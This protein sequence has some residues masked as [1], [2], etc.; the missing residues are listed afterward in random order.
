MLSFSPPQWI[1]QFCCLAF[2][3]A[4]TPSTFTKLIRKLTFGRKDFVS[5]LDIILLYHATLDEHIIWVKSLLE[6]ILKFGLTVIPNSS[7]QDG[8][9]VFSNR[10]FV[11]FFGSVIV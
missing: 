4:S 6:S 5:Y 2:G 11:K 1:K 3:L 10:I 8:D 7:D 9:G